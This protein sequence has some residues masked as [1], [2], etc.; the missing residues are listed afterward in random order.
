MHER[1]KASSK[2]DY[3]AVLV[4]VVCSLLSPKNFSLRLTDPVDKFGPYLF[5]RLMT[6]HRPPK[7]L[8]FWKHSSS[9]AK[10]VFLLSPHSHLLVAYLF[11]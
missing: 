7:R 3:N 8:L 11:F 4:D 10:N 5:Y 2:A 1:I 6:L 9:L